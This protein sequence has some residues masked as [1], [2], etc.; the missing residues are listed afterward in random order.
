MEK[1]L[2]GRPRPKY[3][4]LSRDT[5][6]TTPVALCFFFLW[7][8]CYTC[9]S[10]GRLQNRTPRNP[11]SRRN[12]GGKYIYIYIGKSSISCL[13]LVSFSSYFFAYFSPI[14]WIS[15]FFYSVDGQGFCNATSPP[16][17][18]SVNLAFRSLKTGLG[19][20]VYCRK[21]LPLKPSLTKSSSFL[22]EG[23]H[24]L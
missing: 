19:G 1:G 12:I 10:L 5:R 8:R 11:E 16:P 2:Q 6:R 24:S 23:Y 22:K 13:F 18:P 3:P 4:P 20:G 7:Y 14:F 17:I 9:K 15:E 21:S